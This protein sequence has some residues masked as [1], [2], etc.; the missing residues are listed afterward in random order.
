MD[1]IVF[2]GKFAP[3]LSQKEGEIFVDLNKF[4]QVIPGTPKASVRARKTLV[5]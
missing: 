4:H 1:D 2:G 3:C 5:F